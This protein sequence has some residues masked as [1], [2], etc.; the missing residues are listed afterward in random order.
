MQTQFRAFSLRP[1]TAEPLGVGNGSREDVGELSG[2]N[3][4]AFLPGDLR[5]WERQ[6]CRGTAPHLTSFHG[7]EHGMPP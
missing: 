4:K 6:K 1:V 3:S 5:E 2:N 7:F